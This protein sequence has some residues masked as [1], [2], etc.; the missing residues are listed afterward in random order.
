M[1]F[2]AV[3]RSLVSLI[4]VWSWW[5][6]FIFLQSMASELNVYESQVNEYKHEIERLAGDLQK[7]KKKYFLQIK[8][9]QQIK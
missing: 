5:H 3:K 7:V 8:K 1:M 2:V 4:A 6:G 9:E